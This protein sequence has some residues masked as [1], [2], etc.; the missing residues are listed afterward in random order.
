MDGPM[1]EV[2]ARMPLAEAVLWL[3]RYVG[4]ESHLNA[5]F[6]RYRGRCYQRIIRF[7][8]MVHLIA[9]ALLEYHGSGNQS[10][11]RAQESGELEAS[12]SAAYGKLR[13]LPIPLSMGFFAESTDRLRELF[14]VEA[15][16]KPPRSLRAF[17][18]ITLDGKAIKRVAKR[19][20]PLRGVGGGLLGGRALVAMEFASGMALGMHAHPDGDANDVRFTAD[21]LAELRGRVERRRLWM[22]DRQFCDL[23]RLEQFAASGDHFLVRY[24]AKLGFHPDP[25]RAVQEGV[26]RQGRRY[27]EE[28]GWLG[29]PTHSKRRYVRR[30]TL[31]RPGEEEIIV[32]TSLLSPE[33][34]LAEDLLDLYLERWGIERMFQKVTEV[35]GLEALIGS[36]PEAN[37]FQFAFCLLLYNQI[38]TVRAYVAQHQERD[39]E[40]I[41]LEQV[42]VD[43]QREL[44]AWN[45]VFNPATT[46]DYLRR[47]TLA[48]TRRRLNRLLRCAWS[49]RWIKTH[50]T[51]RRSKKP[52]KRKKT[53]GSVYRILQKSAK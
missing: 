14:P 15:R 33:K 6:E 3:W 10:F 4:D 9:D 12:I 39:F 42:F 30:I 17:E 1:K 52:T 7:P 21:L 34:Y 23:P 47:T 5:V 16:R 45:V 36:T 51:K 41:S 2:L 38:Q 18:V 40:T 27:R 26:D 25:Q 31:Y 37:I 29:R 11:S 28:W 22:A 53:H 20:K 35:F 43:V 24:N 49:D 8:V 13:R 50:N 46:I 48:Q 32:V 44:I 19:L